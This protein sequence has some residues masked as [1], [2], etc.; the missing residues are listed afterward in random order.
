VTAQPP[1]RDG[2]TTNLGSLRAKH[3]LVFNE[4]GTG[5]T[6]CHC[7]F[8][9]DY[10]S[11]CGYGDSIVAHLLSVGLDQ[12]AAVVREV[13]ELR[14]AHDLMS[15]QFR[16]MQVEKEHGWREA[17][18]WQSRTEELEAAIVELA[19]APRAIR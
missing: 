11:D 19:P 6:G 7:G 3:W 2:E 1:A 8:P 15:R 4:I 10:D 12:H 14:A 16:L 5:L 17:E 13:E 9:A 18:K